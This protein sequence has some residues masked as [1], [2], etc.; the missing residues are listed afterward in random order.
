MVSAVGNFNR[1]S[2]PEMKRT[3]FEIA[4]YID[5]H[6]FIIKT[7]DS[8]ESLDLDKNRLVDTLYEWTI[9]D[10]PLELEDVC[11][12]LDAFFRLKNEY[13]VHKIL[14]EPRFASNHSNP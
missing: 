13:E 7:D 4:M 10:G 12:L 11:E 6:V 1:K 3:L 8:P 9:G 2:E 14:N 5:G